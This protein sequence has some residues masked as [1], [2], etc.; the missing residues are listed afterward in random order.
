[1]AHP[2]RFR[3][4]LVSLILAAFLAAGCGGGG[5][6]VSRS[7][8]DMLQEELDAALALVMETETARD[9]A[10]AEVTRL[11]GELATANTSISSL[12]TELATANT[13]V[14]SLTDDLSDAQADVTRLTNQIGTAADATSLQGMLAAANAR[15]TKLTTDLATANGQV[16]TL[17]GQLTVAQSEAASLRRLLTA[18]QTQVTEE[19]D[20]ADQA[21]VDAQA[22]ITQQ[23]QQQTQGLEANQRAQKLKE[24]FSSVT[25]TTTLSQIG[26]ATEVPTRGSLRVTRGGHSTVTLSGSGIRT[27][28]MR[29]TSGADGGKTVVYADR[30]LTRPLLAHFG[31]FRDPDAPQINAAADVTVGGVSVD[32]AA[33]VTLGTEITNNTGGRATPNT[34]VSFSHGLR[35]SLGANDRTFEGAVNNT[36]WDHDVNTLT[37]EEPRGVDTN[38]MLMAEDDSFS[39]SVHGVSGQF[40]CRGTGCMITV[41]GDYN[42]DGATDE[43]E[44]ANVE[45]ASEGGLFFRPGSAGSTV[46]LCDDAARCT[47][48]TDSEYMV[49]GYWREDPTSAAAD[50]KVGVFAQAFGGAG[51]LTSVTATYDGTAAGMY[52]EQDPNDPVDTHRQGEFT[53]DVSLQVDNGTLSGDID[54]FVTTPTG[55]S[56]QPRTAD[57]WVVRL[58]SAAMTGDGFL[59]GTTAYI[60]NLSGV[61]SGTWTDFPVAAHANAADADGMANSTPPAITGTFNTRIVDF[62]HILGAYGAHKR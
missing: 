39:G 20:R 8:H 51:V 7:T 17:T 52:V 29:L 48:G 22:E 27:S 61:K 1:M 2:G 33:L 58:R 14:T 47:A 12:T 32:G 53:A 57:R 55:G 6:D 59:A 43:N 10:R 38:R 25:T 13:S 44:L 37:D 35:S 11:T 9:A 24:A 31:N 50:Y 19:R 40:L 5:D 34:G 18:A 15:V 46:S 56:A 45:I 3:F 49:F 36:T 62:V 21:V 26:L 42:D 23:V 41:T 54:D 30:E 28:E 16:T 60:D 4:T